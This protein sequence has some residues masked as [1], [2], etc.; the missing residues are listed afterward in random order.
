MF[1]IHH[2]IFDIE[3]LCWK[4]K[5]HV[6]LLKMNMINTVCSTLCSVFFFKS[7]RIFFSIFIQCNY[8]NVHYMFFSCTYY[9]KINY[10]TFLLRFLS[11]VANI[12]LLE[13]G[14]HIIGNS[15]TIPLT[16]LTTFQNV[17]GIMIKIISKG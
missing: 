5:R 11:A 16:P 2:N 8:D 17:K 15:S 12:V 13:K 4:G 6:H 3:T 14:S 10:F 9:Q 1:S 7:K